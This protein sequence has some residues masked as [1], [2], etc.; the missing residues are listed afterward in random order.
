[1]ADGSKPKTLN[2]LQRELPSIKDIGRIYAEVQLAEDYTA[3]IELRPKVGDGMK[4]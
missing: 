2:D 4:G 3:A 1:V